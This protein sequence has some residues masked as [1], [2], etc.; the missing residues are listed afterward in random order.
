VRVR[1]SEPVVQIRLR[2]LVLTLPDASLM[3]FTPSSS[4]FR[5]PS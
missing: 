5:N 2:H 3:S 1:C 4:S